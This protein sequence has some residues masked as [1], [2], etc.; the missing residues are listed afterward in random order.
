[1]LSISNQGNGALNIAAEKADAIGFLKK[2][3][4]SANYAN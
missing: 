4:E 3:A 2:M 1:M